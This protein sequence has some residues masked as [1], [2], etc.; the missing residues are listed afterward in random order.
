M[1]V[2]ILADDDDF[3]GPVSARFIKREQLLDSAGD[4]DDVTMDSTAFSLHYRSIARSDS[5]DINSRQLCLTSSSSPRSSMDFTEAKRLCEEVLDA[6]S[7]SRDSNEMS[8]EGEH[9]RSYQFDTVSPAFD[10]PLAE[11]AV[12]GSPQRNLDGSVASPV[13]RLHQIHPSDSSTKVKSNCVIN[14]S[15]NT[16]RW[17]NFC[18][19]VAIFI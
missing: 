5:G 8:I 16:S 18:V 12:K 19:L 2:L 7:A 15:F 10:A 6:E 4:Y 13:A 9:Q 11:E 1:L 3:R 17:C 14:L